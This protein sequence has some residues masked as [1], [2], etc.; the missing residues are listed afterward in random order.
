[1]RQV[2][3]E[4]YKNFKCTA[5]ACRH[6]CCRGWE[7]DIDAVTAEKYAAVPGE[8]G[9]RLRE[10][11]SNEG[12]PHFILAEGERC[13]FLNGQNLCDVI[14]TL[15]EGALCG[16]C[17]DHPRFRT[18]LSDRTETG[19]G[20][21]C[22]EAARLLLTENKPVRL[23]GEGTETL[24]GEEKALLRARSCAFRAVYSGGGEALAAAFG[25]SMP[26]HDA[27]WWAGALMELERMDES[28]TEKLNML[29]SLPEPDIRLTARFEHGYRNLLWYFIYRHFMSA[30]DDGDVISKLRFAVLAARVIRALDG[31]CGESER[32][33]NA[34]L[35]SAEIE[36]SEENLEALFDML[37]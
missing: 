24:T 26:E 9:R 6:T 12:G 8:F 13:P 36:Y 16:I 2:Y 23:T 7:I 4:Y 27:G 19:L 17:T 10:N 18:F 25:F 32:V 33:E 29:K 31:L 28:W 35:F 5:S 34:R 22:E 15:G 37:A 11:I 3:P 20:L 1:M 30:L 14:L 21:C